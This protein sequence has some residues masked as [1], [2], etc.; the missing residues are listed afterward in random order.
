MVNEWCKEGAGLQTL[1]FS[2]GEKKRR[3]IHQIKISEYSTDQ[4]NHMQLSSSHT[5]LYFQDM[6]NSRFWRWPN[7]SPPARCRKEKIISKKSSLRSTY[8]SY[9]CYNCFGSL[10]VLPLT[11][12]PLYFR[13]WVAQTV[14][15]LS[16]MQETRVRFLGWEDTLEK[17]IATHSSILA[18]RI[19]WTEE[20]GRLWSMGSQRVGHDWATSLSLFIHTTTL[21]VA[22]VSWVNPMPMLHILPM[23]H[24]HISTFILPLSWALNTI[25]NTHCVWVLS[26][27]QLFVT[28]WTVAPHGL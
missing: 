11:C 18:W 13:G 6:W 2:K 3:G 16:A 5:S 25:P 22:P 28:T 9:H 15:R 1:L 17:G 20:P 26:R 27:V 14:K 12:A 10:T 7:R 23:Y 8:G 19:P 21:D 4:Q 24:G